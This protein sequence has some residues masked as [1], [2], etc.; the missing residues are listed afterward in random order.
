VAPLREITGSFGVDHAF[1]AVGDAEVMLQA[2]ASC[3]T[4]GICTI[5]GTPSRSARIEL[6]LSALYFPRL[7]I[8]VSQ[9]GDGIPSRDF[10]WLVDLYARGELLLD[11]LIT[12]VVPLA[13]SAE[14]FGGPTPA[15][16]VRTV[17][18]CAATD[19][20]VALAL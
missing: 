6:P 8:R 9:Y 5:L 10:P 17:I 2:L 3:D 11:E 20:P 1:E 13:R 15:D 16:V 19:G 7:Q 14:A 4:G 12:R 18:D